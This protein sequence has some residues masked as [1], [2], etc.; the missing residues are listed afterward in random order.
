M[1]FGTIASSIGHVRGGRLRALG[2]SGLKR[3]SHA[4]DVPTLAESA[5]P[6]FDVTTWDGFFVPAKTPAAAV[7]RLHAETVKALAI[8]AVRELIANIGY[9][10]TG[11]TPAQLAEFVRA[12][13]ALWSKVIREAGIRAD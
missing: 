11:T 7:T 12:E 2:V 5:L 6:G 3:S 4:P 10:P 1:F 13:T 8:P 9:E